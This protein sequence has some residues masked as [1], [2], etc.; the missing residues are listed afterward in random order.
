MKLTRKQAI[1]ELLKLKEKELEILSQ[2]DA[3]DKIQTL[4]E[5]NRILYRDQSRNH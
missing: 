5:V 2:F 3:K 1:E 4:S